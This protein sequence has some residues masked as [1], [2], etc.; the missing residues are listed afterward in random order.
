MKGQVTTKTNHSFKLYHLQHTVQKERLKQQ[1]LHK[2]Q[3]LQPFI[4]G[5]QWE[6]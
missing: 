6:E 5:I 4:S 1:N 3:Y 2:T